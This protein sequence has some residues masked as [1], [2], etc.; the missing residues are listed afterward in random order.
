MKRIIKSYLIK[1]VPPYLL[2]YILPRQLYLIYQIY[3]VLMVLKKL[4]Q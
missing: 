2:Y 1:K 3:Y 4:N